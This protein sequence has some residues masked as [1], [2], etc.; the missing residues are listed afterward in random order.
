MRCIGD[1]HVS[2][3]CFSKPESARD[4]TIGFYAPEVALGEAMH[5]DRLDQSSLKHFNTRPARRGRP[6]RRTRRSPLST[7]FTPNH[8]SPNWLRSANPHPDP[9]PAGAPFI[10]AMP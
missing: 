6:G 5:I 2:T 8:F 10:P 1:V 9:T 4:T 7:P 3:L